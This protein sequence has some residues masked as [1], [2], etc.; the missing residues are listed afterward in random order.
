MIKEGIILKRRGNQFTV[1]SIDRLFTKLIRVD[2]VELRQRNRQEM[3][4][5]DV[6]KSFCKCVQDNIIASYDKPGFFYVENS[7]IKKYFTI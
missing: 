3:L 1:V 7:K 6:F 5:N 2:D 4:N